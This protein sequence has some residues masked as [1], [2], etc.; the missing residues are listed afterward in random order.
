MA[1]FVAFEAEFLVAVEGRV[2]FFGAQKTS[3]RLS[4][5]GAIEGLVAIQVAVEAL[6]RW[7][8][9]DE[10]AVLLRFQAFELVHKVEFSVL[11]LF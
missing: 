8:F 9:L 3:F 5:I 10:I 1:C 4:L 6:Y 7:I 2:A 11:L